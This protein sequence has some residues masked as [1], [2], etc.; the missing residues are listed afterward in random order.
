MKLAMSS[1]GKR[2]KMHSGAMLQGKITKGEEKSRSI[3]Q[4]L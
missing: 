2:L 4:Q 1:G 3:W